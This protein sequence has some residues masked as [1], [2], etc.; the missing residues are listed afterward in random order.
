MLGM[1]GLVLPWSFILYQEVSEPLCLM[2]GDTVDSPYSAQQLGAQVK[3]WL[4]TEI[5]L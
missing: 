5:R 3:V 2:S 4:C 1:E